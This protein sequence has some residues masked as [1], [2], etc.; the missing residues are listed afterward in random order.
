M[1]LRTYKSHGDM[2]VPAFPGTNATRRSC[3]GTMT[4]A[5]NPFAW[6]SVEKAIA[7]RWT[8]RDIKAKR[9]KLSPVAENDMQIL[10][11]LG[12]V[13]IL[14]NG[15]TLTAAGHLVLD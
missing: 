8:L 5:Q 4:E 1:S 6:F 9:L 13:E 11:G 12:L 7:L 2:K 14:D 3:I 10:I 15:P